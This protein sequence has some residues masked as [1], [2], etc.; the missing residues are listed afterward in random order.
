[1]KAGDRRGSCPEPAPPGHRWP[2]QWSQDVR[3][4]GEHLSLTISGEADL[5]L[6]NRFLVEQG[7]DVYALQPKKIS[8]ED[9]FIQIVGTD[10]GL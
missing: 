3:A 4:D 10:G 2:S 9:L 6:I 5:P 7:V 1:L 8:L